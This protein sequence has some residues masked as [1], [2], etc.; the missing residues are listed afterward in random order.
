VL[1]EPF[2]VLWKRAMKRH[3]DPF[4]VDALRGVDSMR[5]WAAATRSV[6]RHFAAQD[7][8]V[9]L[10]ARRPWQPAA[11]RAVTSPALPSERE[12]PK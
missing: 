12:A 7:D 6:D 3:R 10:S 11:E 4:V 8:L 2:D 9:R 1:E 5:S